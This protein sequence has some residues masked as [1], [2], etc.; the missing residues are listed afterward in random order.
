MSPRETRD[1]SIRWVS[2]VRSDGLTHSVNALVQLCIFSSVFHFQ[3]YPQTWTHTQTYMYVCMCVS[4]YI[5]Y[6]YIIFSCTHACRTSQARDWNC[7]PAGSILNLLSHQGTLHKHIFL[8]SQF[9]KWCSVLQSQLSLSLALKNF[10]LPCEIGDWDWKAYLGEQRHEQNREDDSP[11][12]VLGTLVKFRNISELISPPP[13]TLL[14]VGME[15]RNSLGQ[16]HLRLSPHL[17]RF[18]SSR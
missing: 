12:P 17:P 11:S 1:L 18:L 14:T 3:I 4:I 15:N 8:F 5:L 13:L 10:L 2:E 6:I 7:T 9:S 16:G